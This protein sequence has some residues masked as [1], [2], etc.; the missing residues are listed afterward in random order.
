[1]LTAA[2]SVKLAGY[3]AVWGYELMQQGCPFLNFSRISNKFCV[4]IL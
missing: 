4:K 1:M 3:A 2:Y